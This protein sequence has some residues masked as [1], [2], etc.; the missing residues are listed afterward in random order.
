MAGEHTRSGPSLARS[1]E[2]ASLMEGRC[3]NENPLGGVGG[4]GFFPGPKLCLN[5]VDVLIAG[6]MCVGGGGARK[7]GRLGA[8]DGVSGVKSFS[9]ES[10]DEMRCCL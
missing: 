2:L 8:L 7:T 4:F 3:K 10:G 6:G 5:D 1:A 9:G